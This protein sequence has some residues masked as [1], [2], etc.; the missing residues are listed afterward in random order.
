MKIE[1]RILNIIQIFLVGIYSFTSISDFQN[2]LLNCNEHKEMFFCWG[3]HRL[4]IFI[5][6]TTTWIRFQGNSR[7]PANYRNF[8]RKEILII[9][10]KFQEIN[11]AF[12]VL[13]WFFQ[14][15]PSYQV[16]SLINL[17]YNLAECKFRLRKKNRVNLNISFY[18]L[19]R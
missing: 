11:Y 2:N 7:P 19:I 10:Q 18:C 12:D 14:T 17:G 6:A 5:F 13:I 4:L 1:S 9:Y 3:L 15:Q 16:R 8:Q